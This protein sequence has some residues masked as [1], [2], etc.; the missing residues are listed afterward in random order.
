MSQFQQP[1]QPRKTKTKFHEFEKYESGRTRYLRFDVNALADFEQETGMGFA[2]MINQK[3]LFGGT[4]ALLWA[5]LKFQ[6]KALTV[7]RVGELMGEYLRDDGVEPGEHNINTLMQVTLAAAVEQGAL[8]KL[9][10]IDED[11]EEDAQT[12]EQRLADAR[13]ITGETVPNVEDP[14]TTNTTS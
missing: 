9:K 3:A 4:R 8:G 1:A 12:E 6:D 13:R 2:Q 5:G 14:S 10:R 7:E 11:D